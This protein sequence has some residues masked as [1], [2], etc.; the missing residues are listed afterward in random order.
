MKPHEFSRLDMININLGEGCNL[1]CRYCFQTGILHS[2]VVCSAPE[3]SLK[4]VDFLLQVVGSTTDR[5]FTIRF[6][7]GE[8]LLHFSKMKSIVNAL[9]PVQSKLHY[10]TVTN[11]TLIT[12]EIVEFF[13]TNGFEV[14]ISNDGEATATTRGCNV[15]EDDALLRK[16]CQIK[17]MHI[18]CVLSALNTDYSKNMEYF[19]SKIGKYRDSTHVSVNPIYNTGCCHDEELFAFDLASFKANVDKYFDNITI[20]Q[21]DDLNS[22][23]SYLL[24]RYMSRFVTVQT[25]AAKG[26]DVTKKISCG[27]DYNHINIDT[28]GNAYFCH[29]CSDV[30]GSIDDSLDKLFSVYAERDVYKVVNQDMCMSC[31]AIVT[32]TG[33]CPMVSDDNRKAYYC[34]VQ[35]TIYRAIERTLSRLFKEA[36]KQ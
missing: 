6:T 30:I 35:K 33:G 26:V 11:G 13:N 16:I 1:S 12:D 24:R 5:K 32:C 25:Y 28:K 10:I 2:G 23:E 8:P 31:E 17:D 14:G 9:E 22:P 4:V 19:K 29:N 21:F 3:V 27:T 36:Q 18:V 34:F 7:G 20:S 15:L